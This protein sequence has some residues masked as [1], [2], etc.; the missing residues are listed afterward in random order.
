M[1]S[2]EILK[3][4]AILLYSLA[5]PGSANEQR[6]SWITE[7]PTDTLAYILEITAFYEDRISKA[8]ARTAK[9]AMR[10]VAKEIEADGLH[11]AKIS[12]EMEPP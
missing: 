3:K 10:V 4:Q 1:R 9:E 12:R 7:Q 11:G 2:S 5:L 8:G 6:G